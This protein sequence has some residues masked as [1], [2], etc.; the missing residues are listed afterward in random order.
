MSKLNFIRRFFKTRNKEDRISPDSGR[1]QFL[2][3]SN[4]RIRLFIVAL[5]VLLPLYFLAIYFYLNERSKEISESRDDLVNITNVFVAENERLIEG[6]HLI[7]NV[8][9]ELPEVQGDDYEKCSGL[10]ASILTNSYSY[11][12]FGVADAD[13]NIICSGLPFEGSVNVADRSYFRKTMETDEFSVGEYQV[14]RITKKSTINFGHPTHDKARNKRVVFAALDL[15][16]TNESIPINALPEKALFSL[17]DGNGILLLRYPESEYYVGKSVPDTT[18]E[19]LLGRKEGMLED[20]SLDGVTRIFNI[21]PIKDANLYIRIGFS[22]DLINAEANRGLEN[23]I[24]LLGIATIFVFFILEVGGRQ[25]IIRQ[26]EELQK[27]DRLKDEFVSLVSHQLRTP[28]TSMKWSI[29][30]LNHKTTG[31]LNDKQKE[32]LQNLGISTEHL[33]V[34]VGELL[35]IGRIESGRLQINLQP[36]DLIGIAKDVLKEFGDQIAKKSIQLKI[37]FVDIMP[38][39]NADPLIMQQILL[40]IF[41]N[42]IKYTPANGRVEISIGYD[43]FNARISV[44]DSGI[45]IPKKDQNLIFN[46]FFRAS[47]VDPEIQGTGLGLNLTKSLVELMDGEIGFISEENKGTTFW[48]M[49]PL[50]LAKNK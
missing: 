41:S 17:V 7:L 16:K 18:K 19:F 39:V 9:S 27:I 43:D 20:T 14:G 42:A 40:N 13:G 46:R 23:N 4:F 29:E 38:S 22:K 8:L 1:E 34:L 24:L 21:K 33:N 11:A 50:A 25:L 35:D 45:G 31:G 3:L 47:N 44:C 10:L 36:V 32:I 15:A 12:L 49:L 2:N 48:I 5:L 37:G 26:I 30:L 28:L 6:A